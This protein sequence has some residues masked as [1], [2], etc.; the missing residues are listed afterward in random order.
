MKYQQALADVAF[1][2]FHNQEFCQRF[3]GKKLLLIAEFITGSVDGEPT[4]FHN[5]FKDFFDSIDCQTSFFILQMAVPRQKSGEEF[6]GNLEEVNK[7]FASDSFDFIFV[8]N[9]L[10]K[11]H[12]PLYAISHL[13]E[14]CRIGGSLLCLTRKPSHNITA[15]LGSNIYFYEDFWRFEEQDILNLFPEDD[16]QFL[17]NLEFPEDCDENGDTR[18]LF[19]QITLKTKSVPIIPP[20]IFNCRTRCKIDLD[21]SNALGYFHHGELDRFGF[22]EATDKAFVVHNYLD[23]YEFFLDKFRD[24]EFTLLELGV[25]WGGSLR[26]WKK[27]FPKAQ[28]IGVDLLE[29]CQ[30]F[31]ES[32]IRIET[33]DLSK[34][35]NLE[36]LK[37]YQPRIIID[38]ASHF[39][40]HQIKAMSVLFSCLPSGGIYIIED[41][42]TSFRLF[43][44][45]MFEN[46]NMKFNDTII[47]AYTFCELINRVVVSKLKLH[48]LFDESPVKNLEIDGLNLEN[49]I[50]EIGLQTEF[51]GVMK[52]ACIFIKR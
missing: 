35:E 52:G 27:F 17:S 32:R 3:V 8:M 48:E 11:V 34:I 31:T 50:N 33:L 24:D 25:F 18:S 46:R 39:W 16:V 15:G 38:D 21:N 37:K 47:D 51:A 20:K 45:S 6:F 13:K 41:M 7:M 44:E 12:H 42:E 23:K 5:I 1:K 49:V 10:E 40:S 29:D 30:N 9:G 36:S 28:I 22:E 4:D 26:M 14:I 43:I 19:S 2:I